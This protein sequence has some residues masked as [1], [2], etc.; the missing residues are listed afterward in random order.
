MQVYKKF[1]Q[2][3]TVASCSVLKIDTSL[4][5]TREYSLLLQQ[6]SDKHV[7]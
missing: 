2:N 4:V 6:E 3:Q 1:K 5:G 7:F